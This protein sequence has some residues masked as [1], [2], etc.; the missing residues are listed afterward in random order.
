MHNN[1]APIET[2]KNLPLE[3][4]LTVTIL[5]TTVTVLALISIAIIAKTWVDGI[6]RM[7]DDLST[8]VLIIKPKATVA[9]LAGDKTIVEDSM[10]FLKAY[11]PIVDAQVLGTNNST[12]AQYKSKKHREI[13]SSTSS[14]EGFFFHKGHLTYE[15]Y[16]YL[17]NKKIGAIHITSDYRELRSAL[18]WQVAFTIVAVLVSLLISATLARVARETIFKPLKELYEVADKVSLNHN[19]SLRAKKISND[20]IG[21]LVTKFNE[22]LSVI[23][24]NHNVIEKQTKDLLIAQSLAKVGNWQWQV[25]TNEVT[26]SPQALQLLDLPPTIQQPPLDFL[27]N[28]LEDKDGATFKEAVGSLLSREQSHTYV[29]YKIKLINGESRTLVDELNVQYDNDG[30]INKIIAVTQ[31]IT[32]RKKTY[33]DLQLAQKL[34]SIGVMAGGIAH[35][36]NNLLTMIMGHLSLCKISAEDK[37][38]HDD[39]RIL[40]QA[41]KAAYRAKTLTDKLLTFSSSNLPKKMPL[42]LR[43]MLPE[44][45][46]M[47][48]NGSQIIHTI[49]FKKSLLNIDG[50]QSQLRQVIKNIYMNAK[51]SMKNGGLVTTTT[52]SVMMEHFNNHGLVPGYYILVKIKDEGCGINKTDVKKIFDPYYTT[53]PASSGLGLST[54][55]SIIK[56]HG[57]AIEVTSRLN[58]GTEFTFYLPATEND[59]LEIDDDNTIIEKGTGKILLMED[60]E[61]IG[62]FISTLL[63]KYGYIVDHALKGEEAIDHYK[64]SIAENKPYKA[65]ILDLTIKGGLGGRETIE[66]LLKI[67]PKIKAI[68]SSGYSNDPIMEDYRRFGFKASVT[69]PYRGYDLLTTISRVIKNN[70]SEIN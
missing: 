49:N 38:N 23:E 48:F 6:G 39:Y 7:K 20:E 42:S 15:E 10:L 40:D 31:D 11:K 66:E 4:K 24:N 59:V 56:N 2:F 44:S 51:E 53:K 3:K 28:R 36:F 50:D 70:E 12:F 41:E 19:Y 29:E 62:E 57:G 34:D 27:I 45:A 58:K 30:G 67:N 9:L 1:I 63:T 65:V 33:D 26:L 47:V 37:K 18:V 8:H 61:S 13:H 60:E 46:N 35:D 14:A 22:M 68:V 43:T 16:I 21:L 64:N 5:M 54:C 17:G 55:Y 69:K 32:N 25:A 52:D